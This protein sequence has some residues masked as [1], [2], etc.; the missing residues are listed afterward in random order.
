MELLFFYSNV[1]FYQQNRTYFIIIAGAV[2]MSLLAGVF[3]AWHYSK[4]FSEPIQEILDTFRM[5]GADSYPEM[6]K[7]LEKT[8]LVYE[9]RL[10]DIQK[11]LRGS[12]Q[13]QKMSFCFPCAEVISMRKS[14]GKTE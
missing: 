13:Q 7:S 10:H 12:M 14:T 11:Q 6:M 3:L 1:D 8:M 9:Y 5:D 2:L 4:A